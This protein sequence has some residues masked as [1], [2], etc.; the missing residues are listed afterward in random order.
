M[1]WFGKIEINAPIDSIVIVIAIILT[2]LLTENEASPNR[3]NFLGSLHSVSVSLDVTRVGPCWPVIVVCNDVGYNLMSVL[4]LE[5][6]SIGIVSGFCF[7]QAVKESQCV[8][9][10]MTCSSKYC[11]T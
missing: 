11:A 8:D 1:N 2:L 6:P 10:T 7:C 3:L 5:I 4:C 9:E